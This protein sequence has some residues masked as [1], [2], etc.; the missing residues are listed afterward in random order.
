MRVLK[1]E[2]RSLSG[3]VPLANLDDS[4][5]LSA[6]SKD[7]RS[8]TYSVKTLASIRS[9]E[10]TAVA[11]FRRDCQTEEFVILQKLTEKGMH[12]EIDSSLPFIP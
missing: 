1:S 4:L 3:T 7:E 6:L 2:R 11:S 8:N 12:Y 5:Q 9:R 10:A